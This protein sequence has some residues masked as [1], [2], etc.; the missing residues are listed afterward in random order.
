MLLIDNQNKLDQAC[1][2]ISKQSLIAVDTEFERR[3]TYFAKLSLIQVATEAEVYLI[4]ILAG[5]N[6]TQVEQI[7]SN[8]EITK[9]FHA[10]QQDL[11]IFWH[12]FGKLPK[13]IFDTQ[14]AANFCGMGQSI[15]FEDLCWKVCQIR[16]DKT[17]QTSDWSIRPISSE[18]IAYAAAD[19]EN[20]FPLYKNLKAKLEELG[21]IKEYNTAIANLLQESNYKINYANAWKKVKFH[22]RGAEFLVNMQ[23]LSAFREE[24]A[25]TLDVPRRYIATDM[26]LIALCKRLPFTNRELDNLKL[27]SGYLKQG[28]YRKKLLELCA[29]L[30]EVRV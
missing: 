11:E 13:N 27:S 23:H 9:I 21:K 8:K 4:D 17:Y 28:K 15:S 2:I 14:L 29:S 10:P 26:E 1:D 18:Q 22:E 5:L 20:L 30:R 3:T 12:K 25:V 16:I 6:L 19:V 7:L 24:C